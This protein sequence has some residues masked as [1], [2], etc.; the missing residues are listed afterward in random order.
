MSDED[1]QQI[2]LELGVD[3]DDVQAVHS[4]IGRRG[5]IDR[6]KERSVAAI[7]QFYQ[8]YMSKARARVTTGN[9]SSLDGPMVDMIVDIALDT[10]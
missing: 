2:A 6:V 5:W 9:S 8:K 7:I 3:V 4:A 1:A 10:V